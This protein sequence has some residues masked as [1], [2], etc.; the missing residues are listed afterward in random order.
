MKTIRLIP[1]L[2]L[3][4]LGSCSS[5]S[6]ATDYDSTVNFAQFKTYAFLKEG[7]DDLKI[8]DLDKKRILNAIDQEMTAKGYTKSDHPDLVINL[9]TDSKQNVHVNSFYGGWGYGG[10]GWNP[11]MWGPGYQSVST[12][13]EG[14]LYIDVLKASN[15][16]LIW[17][18]K[19]TG[20]LN[21]NSKKREERIKEFT[22]KVLAYFP[23]KI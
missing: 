15:R 19:G 10:W 11:W 3:L 13:T 12:S 14:I 5:I 23:Q 9:F 6:V 17:Q 21:N 18:G 8:S 20:Y 2:A 16:E 4:I 7:I 1:L 22:K